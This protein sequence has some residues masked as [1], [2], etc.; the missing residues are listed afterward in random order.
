[1]NAL[2]ALFPAEGRRFLHAAWGR[3]GPIGMFVGGVALAAVVVSLLLPAWFAAEST[4]LPPSDGSNSFG[5]MSSMIQASVLNQ[6]GIF[7]TQTPSDVVAEILKSRT[8]REEL[9]TKYDLKTTYK[10]KHMDFALRALEQHL[11]V[12]INKAGV[13]TVRMEDRS[14]KRAANMVNDL[15]AMLD[16]FNREALNT[17]AKRTRRF[18]ETR[19]TAVEHQMMQAESTLTSYEKRNKMVASTESGAIGAIASVMAERMNLQVRRSYLSSFTQP[20]SPSLKE[21]DA[22]MGAYERQLAQLPSLKQEG[23][24]LALNAEIQ[25]R[26]FTLL[27]AQYEDA[28]VEEMRDTPTLTVLDVARPPDVRSRPRRGVIVVAASGLATLLALAWAWLRMQ[29]DDAV[30]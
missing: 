18:L 23:S 2:L 21:I 17:R 26:V 28:R 10:A 19:L 22:Q 3:K 14:A 15:V 12:G 8:L 16:R 27:T 20:G 1:M 5:M 25:R 7:S 4:I 6:V 13:I 9:I 11:E 24:R 30:A 29:R